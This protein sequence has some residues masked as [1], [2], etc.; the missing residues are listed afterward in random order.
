MHDTLGLFFASL[1]V[2]LAILILVLDVWG[3]RR[4]TTRLVVKNLKRGLLVAILLFLYFLSVGLIAAGILP[5]SSPV[6]DVLG[7]IFVISLVYVAYG[8]VG[9]WR[10]LQ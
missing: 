9:D 7:T 5:A 8:Y 3:I 2:V 1:N 10:K 6:D 4:F